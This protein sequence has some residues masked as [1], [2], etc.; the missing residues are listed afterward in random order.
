MCRTD[1]IFGISF[2]VLLFLSSCVDVK[3]EF[4][5]LPPGMYRAELKLGNN[6]YPVYDEDAVRERGTAL[7]EGISDDVLPFTMEVTYPEAHPDSF[8]IDIING[9]ETI[10]VKKYLW[11][12]DRSQARDTIR[13]LFPEYN[14]YIFGEFLENTIQGEF[15][16]ENRK[17]YSI[18]FVARHGYIN[19]FEPQLKEPEL[20]VSGEWRVRFRD[21]KGNTWPAVAEFQQDSTYLTGTFLTETG[22]YRYLEGVVY[23]KRLW[24]S[25]FD[26]SHAFLFSAQGNG[27]D[28][29]SG[30][31]Q[32]G[33][34]YSASWTA[35]RDED[36]SLTSPDSLTRK[37]ENKGWE[38][39][40]G[41]DSKTEKTRSL[42]KYISKN[43]PLILSIM[44]TWCP[45]CKDEAEFLREWRNANPNS[46]VDILGL[47]FE[48]FRDSTQAI[49]GIN[50]YKNLLELDYDIW[51]MGSSDKSQA[52]RALPFLD[53][54]IS[55]PTMVFI[56]D[57]NE[58]IRIHT[59]FKGPATSEYKQF[60]KSFEKTIKEMQ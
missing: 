47:A 21:Q 15:V 19:R 22:D 16:D 38:N 41:I 33:V 53:R 52:S 30:F 58:I 36:F 23:E 26:G 49:N 7:F 12:W 51:L 20:D 27:M 35:V 2:V 3:Y 50:R 24:L 43:S 11:G 39:I 4:P 8:V 10:R 56:N 59:G 57:Q 18:P 40:R 25:V 14:S 29:L 1:F 46:G 17:R 32:S 37:A 9:E 42:E 44:G 54:V 28:S 6:P 5:G 55:Y 48:K 34:H 45:N 13:I 60:K 31:F